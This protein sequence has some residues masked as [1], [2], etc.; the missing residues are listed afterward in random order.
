[1]DLEDYEEGKRK[2]VKDFK[3]LIRAMLFDTKDQDYEKIRPGTTYYSGATQYYPNGAV[4]TYCNIFVYLFLQR[5]GIIIDV[6][7]G[8]DWRNN[9]PSVYYT[10]ISLFLKMMVS[11]DI[12]DE[13]DF[14]KAQNFAKFGCPVVVIVPE[15]I[16]PDGRIIDAG[17]IA[18]VY[19]QDE[20]QKNEIDVMICGAGSRAVWGLKSC[21]DTFLKF[22]YKPRYFHIRGK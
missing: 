7:L 6:L 21:Y 16:G 15:K 5:L 4:M 2:R 19:P 11:H 22:G 13:V 20:I 17:H 1:M 14:I 8:V 18:L 10:P 9:K 12:A 3:D